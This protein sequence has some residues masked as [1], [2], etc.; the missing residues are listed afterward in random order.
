MLKSLFSRSSQLLKV[1]R[2]AFGVL[3]RTALDAQPSTLNPDGP[4][5]PGKAAPLR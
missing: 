1:E 5:R 2:S 3:T 4:A